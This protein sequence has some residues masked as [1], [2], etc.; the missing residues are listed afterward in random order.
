[1]GACA[2]LETLRAT[3]CRAAGVPLLAGAP[4]GVA[5]VALATDGWTPFLQFTGSL[6]RL[7]PMAFGST[8]SA[9]PA[10]TATATAPGTASGVGMDMGESEA[11]LEQQ[12]VLSRDLLQAAGLPPTLTEICALPGLVPLALKWVSQWNSRP[13]AQPI[14]PHADTDADTTHGGSGSGSGS[15]SRCPWVPVHE[16]DEVDTLAS[17]SRRLKRERESDVPVVALTVANPQP[18]GTEDR[19]WPLVGVDPYSPKVHRYNNSDLNSP[20]H[21]QSPS[22]L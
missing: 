6:R 2:G 10:P 12:Q 5:L 14:D 22:P 15:S 16:K 7:L 17:S 8:H 18:I 13:G 4:A 11:H 21:R 9:T 1:V 3:L 20:L 19:D